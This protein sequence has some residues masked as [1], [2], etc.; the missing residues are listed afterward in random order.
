[1]VALE[2]AIIFLEQRPTSLRALRAR[3]KSHGQMLGY[4]GVRH[5]RER[6]GLWRSRIGVVALAALLDEQAF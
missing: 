2:A 1:M 6:V 5:E 3:D 4:P